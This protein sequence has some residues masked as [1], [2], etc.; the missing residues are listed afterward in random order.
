MRGGVGEWWWLCV[1]F[2]GGEEPERNLGGLG[3]RGSE[4]VLVAAVLNEGC[5]VLCE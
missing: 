5:C 2:G 1:R 3:E 4:W